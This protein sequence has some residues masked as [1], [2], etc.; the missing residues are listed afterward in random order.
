MKNDFQHVRS[1]EPI[2]IPAT[3]YNAMLDAAQAHRN[4]RMNLSP[5]GAGFD[6]LHVYVENATGRLLERFNVVGLDGPSETQNPDIFCNRIAFKGVVPRK[7]HAQRYAILQ[8]DAAPG[9]MVRACLSGVTIAKVRVERAPNNMGGL[10]CNAAADT[11]E[12]LELGGGASILWIDTGTG[13]KWSIIRIGSDFSIRKGKLAE[14]C[15]EGASTVRVKPEEN[16]QD[17]IEVNVPYPDD[18]KECPVDHPCRFYADGGE[19]MLL[20]I[21]CPN[22]DEEDS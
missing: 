2:V 7:E 3:A 21:A 10:S 18:L 6:S 14:K 22:E 16:N 4:R 5:R 12:Y 17:V 11:T 19:W 1:G 15:S 20:D 13:V 9:M 8:Q